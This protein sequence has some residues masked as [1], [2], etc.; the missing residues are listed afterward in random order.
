MRWGY[1][2]LDAFPSP[3]RGFLK[4][5]YAVATIADG[6]RWLAVLA[7][8]IAFL[9]VGNHLAR[10]FGVAVLLLWLMYTAYLARRWLRRA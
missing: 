9:V 3:L 10:L 4:T 5:Y 7:I 6:L 8:G 1:R 2:D